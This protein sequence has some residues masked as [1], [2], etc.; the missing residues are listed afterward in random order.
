MLCKVRWKVYEVLLPCIQRLKTSDKYDRTITFRH[1]SFRKWN[2]QGFNCIWRVA[3]ALRQYSLRQLKISSRSMKAWSVCVDWP[4][5]SISAHNMQ[6]GLRLKWVRNL[7]YGAGWNVCGRAERVYE[8]VH[9]ALGAAQPNGS[10]APVHA[11]LAF[12][13]PSRRPTPVQF[14]SGVVGRL[15]CNAVESDRT[16][17][18]FFSFPALLI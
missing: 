3:R 9:V 7:R 10:S 8:L 5:R 15:W 6:L 16:H 11:L 4:M 13:V 14:Q 2:Q 1:C 12:V 17:V 18:T